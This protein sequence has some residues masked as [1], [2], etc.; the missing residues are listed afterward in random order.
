MCSR[1]RAQP[2]GEL[3]VLIFETEVKSPYSIAMFFQFIDFRPQ[4]LFGNFMGSS[5]S[6]RCQ[7]GLGV[8]SELRRNG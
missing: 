4:Y 1:S 8:Q 6:R 7:L 5:N 2:G 3:I